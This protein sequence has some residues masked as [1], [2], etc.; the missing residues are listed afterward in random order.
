MTGRCGAE[1]F[2]TAELLRKWAPFDETEFYCCGSRPFMAGAQAGLESLNVP[3]S[4]VHYEFF[5][6]LQDLATAGP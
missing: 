6:P 5:E 1:G 3:A 4:R 2:V